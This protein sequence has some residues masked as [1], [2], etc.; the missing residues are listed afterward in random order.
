MF[1]LSPLVT[2]VGY[3]LQMTHPVLISKFTT[4]GTH[5]NRFVFVFSADTTHTSSC[6]SFFRN[7]FYR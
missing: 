3:Y 4:K 2:A 1:V 5:F 6:S 7:S